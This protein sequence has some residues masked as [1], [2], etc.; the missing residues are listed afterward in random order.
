VLFDIAAI[1]L[2]PRLRVALDSV[3]RLPPLV[4]FAS[5]S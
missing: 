4:R 2:A 5:S 3:R 1:T